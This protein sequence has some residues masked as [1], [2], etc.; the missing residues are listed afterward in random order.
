M[1]VVRVPVHA[2]RGG[3]VLGRRAGTSPVGSGATRPP[4]GSRLSPSS[5]HPASRFLP[6]CPPSQVLASV[7]IREPRIPI[8][9]N[10]TGQPFGS[11]AEIGALLPRQLVEA[12]Q[13]EGTLRA[14]VAAGERAGRAGCSSVRR[15]RLAGGLQ[16]AF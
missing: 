14:L 5:S 13:W 1:R 9:S 3:R 7:E 2:G 16:P 12:V 10:V 4:S 11:A 8:Y 15:P 6:S